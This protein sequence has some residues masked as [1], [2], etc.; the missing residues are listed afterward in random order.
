MAD[1]RVHASRNFLIGVVLDA[2]EVEAGFV[3]HG[4]GVECRSRSV[5]IGDEKVAESDGVAVVGHSGLLRL[6]TIL[7]SR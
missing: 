3:Q 6:M 1:N 2:D 4:G 5:G 7:F